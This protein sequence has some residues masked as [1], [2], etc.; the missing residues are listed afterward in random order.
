VARRLVEDTAP[1]RRA[2]FARVRR[3]LERAAGGR[4]P[5]GFRVLEVVAESI[6]LPVD[7]AFAHEAAAF[8]ELAM[9]AEAHALMHAFSL[10]RVLRHP[11]GVP[12]APPPAVETVALLGGGVPAGA[13]AHLLAERDVSVRVRDRDRAAVAD[14]LH[15]VRETAGWE[16]RQARLGAEAERRV[17]SRVAGATG[18]GGFGT[19]DMAV[20]MAVGDASRKREV[21]REAEDHLRD[22][23]LLATTALDLSVGA[24]CEGLARPERVAGLRF[25]PSPSDPRVAEIVR[26]PAT[27]DGVVAALHALARRLDVPALVVGDAPG[28]LLHRLAVAYVMEGVALLAEGA[29]VQDVDGAAREL[30]L[31][32]GPLAT[33]DAVGLPALARIAAAVVST[34]DPARSADVLDSLVRRAVLGV[35]AGKGF[36]TY[37]AGHPPRPAESVAALLRP[38]DAPTESPTAPPALPTPEAMGQRL[39]LALA[40]EAARVLDEGVVATPDEIDLAVIVGLGFPAFLGGLLYHADQLGARS[41]VASLDALAAQHGPRFQPASLLRRLAAEGRAFHHRG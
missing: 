19:V 13:L 2:L 1:G 21:L 20:E 38:A 4:N 6:A 16:R 28:G 9:T 33:A 29:S 41:V 35:Q 27:G 40:N 15:W 36:Y 3:G 10:R 34:D 31:A 22:D 18:F 25:F 24:L 17:A 26:G 23:A 7:E 5:A 14:A 30:G 8:G 12:N 39:L 32:D 37:K 11:P